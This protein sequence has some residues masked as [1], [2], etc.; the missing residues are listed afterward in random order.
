VSRKADKAAA[1][2]R[3]ELA[4]LRRR[5]AEQEV[6]ERRY[7]QLAEELRASGEMFRSMAD[8]A[9]DAI[10]ALDERGIVSYIN[11]AGEK[12][13]G[14]TAEE[15][16]G[17]SL[18][19]TLIPERFR[20][21]SRGAFAARTA[22]G[23][24]GMLGAIR[25]FQALSKNGKE[26]PVEASISAVRSGERTF[27]ITFC[28]DIT[29]RKQVE[30]ELRES[31]RRYRD[32]IEN[33][34]DV[35]FTLDPLGRFSY[36]S[37]MIGRISHYTAEEIV[38]QPFTR[39]IHPDDLTGLLGSFERT[40]TGDLEPYE[41]R[42]LDKDGISFHVRTSSRPLFKNGDLVGLAGVMTDI[43][44]RKQAEE[45]LERYRGNLEDLVEERTKELEGATEGLRRSERYYRSLIRNAG[46]MI[47]ILNADFTIRWGS[48]S[49]GRIT[50]YT[51]EDIY[52][53]SILDNIH[54]DDIEPAKAVLDHVLNNPGEPQGTVVRFKHKD[55]SYHF[56]EAI[57]TNLLG[58]PALKGIV[59]NTRDITDRV[60]LDEELRHSERYFR[61]LIENAY[62]IIAVLSPD[63]TMGYLSPSLEK[64]S[65]FTQEER[66]G[67]DAF[68]F[69]HPDDLPRVME[70]F[71]RGLEQ[72]GFTDRIEYRWQHADGS[73]HW[74]EAVAT[75]LLDDPVV[76]GIV[77]NAR[78]I[79]DRRL[80]EERLQRLNQCFL[81]LGPDPLE[82]I[83]KLALAGKE[84]LEAELAR[85]GRMEKGDF[86]IF[87]S[88]HAGEGFMLLEDVEEHLCYYLLSRGAVGPVS[89]EDIEVRV[90]EKDPD[91]REHGFRS[92][93][94]HPITVQGESIGCF[95]LLDKEKR[96]YSQ[97][98]VNTLAILSKA[99]SIEEERYASNESLRDFVDIASHELRH[100]VALL[101]GFTETLGSHGSEMDKQTR[102]EI[103]DAIKQSTARISHMVMGLLNISLV[104][105]ER[106]F[107]SKSSGDILLLIE[108]VVSEMRV[109]VQGRE[110][111]VEPAGEIDECEIDPERIHDLLV[112]LLDNAVKYSPEGSEVELTV[113][114]AQDEIMVSVLD[115]G[116]GVPAE[117]REKIFERFYQVEEAQYHS[118]PGLGLGLFLARQ[119]VEGHGGRLWY[120]PRE[121]GGSAFRFTL[122]R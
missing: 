14:Q 51:P 39:F 84:M 117:H 92:C 47:D 24:E 43:R 73:W 116:I 29:A 15:V 3:E 83:Q 9:N 13:F 61:A 103:V 10:M 113:E 115:R 87:S 70:A 56:H 54:P 96:E 121:G 77:V 80:A 59:L 106:F 34:N 58:D 37:P 68:K 78:D 60:L 18:H 27:Y 40:L 95:N 20:D 2:L 62:D 30:E 50:G 75:N 99:I 110:F 91:V 89:T 36:I 12:L 4:E 76:R 44:R 118:K 67:Q 88:L 31:Q 49:A 105:R 72:P 97:L 107:I 112:I 63:G 32:L 45:E 114:T 26:F 5:T 8:S 74:Q 100:P 108:R 6:S 101:A 102:N 17:K 48:P 1:R 104:E 82:N 52:R 90:F 119:I 41:F 86:Y 55:G 23:M 66:L 7:R 28:R 11:Q 42:V 71:A 33:L 25:E 122:P 64:V 35:V 57:V 79:T 16:I 81:G 19:E 109:K 98:E 53:K 69:F 111:S 94:F 22:T 46:D 38:G 65:G 93:H 120:E 21:Y 85:Y